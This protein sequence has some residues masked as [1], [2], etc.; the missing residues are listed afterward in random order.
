ML[1]SRGFY[2]ASEPAGGASFTS[3]RLRRHLRQRGEGCEAEHR[4]YERWLPGDSSVWHQAFPECQRNS[5][6]RGLGVCQTLE[7]ISGINTG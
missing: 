1:L 3:Q 2:Q 6:H 7:I 5:R 4:G